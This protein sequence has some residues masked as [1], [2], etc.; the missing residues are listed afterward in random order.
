MSW[1]GKSETTESVPY[2]ARHAALNLRGIDPRTSLRK[3]IGAMIVIPILAAFITIICFLGQDLFWIQFLPNSKART[4]VIAQIPFE[5]ASG[6]K[7]QRLKEQRRNLVAPVFRVDPKTYEHFRGKIHLFDELL[8]N[9]M[10]LDKQNSSYLFELKKFVRNFNT[11]NETN[12][13]WN[14]VDTLLRSVDPCGRTCI[15]IEGLMIFK[16]ICGDGI[17]D[18]DLSSQQDEDFLLNI[19]IQ[20]AAR[21][22][23]YRSEKEAGRCLKLRLFAVEAA[24]D[25]LQSTYRI[26]KTGIKANI[27][28]NNAATNQKIV[29]TVRETPAVIRKVLANDVIVEGRSVVTPEDYECL[30]AY[31]NALEE[32]HATLLQGNGNFFE[33]LL[34]SFLV[35]LLAY[36]FFCTTRKDLKQLSRKELFLAILLLVFNLVVCRALIGLFEWRMFDRVVD[37]IRGDPEAGLKAIPFDPL[38]LLPYVLPMTLSCLLGTLLIR[39]YVGMLLGVMTILFCN[40]VL[41]QAVEFSIVSLVIIFISTYFARHAYVRGQ[42]M[43]SGVFSGLVFSFAALVFSMGGFFARETVL[44]Q[45]LLAF[46]NCFSVSMIVL[47]ILP[48]FENIFKVCSNICLIELTDYRSPLLM[49]LQIL[50]PGTYQ[51][52]LMVSN[53]AEQTAIS[54]HANPFLCRALA[55]YHDVG[56]LVKPEYFT[57]NQGNHKNPHDEKTPFMSALIIKSHVKEGVALAKAARLPPRVIDGITEH[58][59]TSVIRYFYAK[60]LKQQGG[61]TAEVEKTAFKYDGPCPRSRETLILSLADS[62]EAASRSLY[63]PTPQ[64]I[65]TLIDNIIDIKIAEK[66]FDACQINFQEISQ[67]RQSFFV[68]L[69]NMLHSRI[70]YDDV[71]A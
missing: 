34:F 31:R 8:D 2:N 28:F 36:L 6:I 37:F 51:H 33:R 11:K 57:E 42:V 25:V 67:L 35:L 46:L 1:E 19:E 66:Q 58:H 27:V 71:R 10:D 9:F 16:E 12:L 32:A 55:M 48:I 4:Q 65:Q 41:S 17:L 23:H 47:T 15:L 3:H 53:L 24:A 64:S 22:A 13:N 52:S 62:I 29:K 40:M 5:Y 63:N 56:K 14:D 70:S 38:S 43:R 60:A 49:K 26:L 30:L 20:G 39:T 45:V 50:A 61:D 7:T 54:V 59:G 21:H 68:T 69:L 44:V 18:Q